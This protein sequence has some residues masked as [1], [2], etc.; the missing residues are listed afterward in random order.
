MPPSTRSVPTRR[1]GNQPSTHSRGVARLDL[2]SFDPTG[3]SL[4]DLA[5][6]P[7]AAD[8][9]R[10]SD[11]RTDALTDRAAIQ[12]AAFRRTIDEAALAEHSLARRADDLSARLDQGARFITELDSRLNAT[13]PAAALLDRA[14]SALVALESV[15]TQLRDAH[16]GQTRCIESKLEHHRTLVESAVKSHD[17]SLRSRLAEIERNALA[18]GATIERQ[19]AALTARASI[20]ADNAHEQFNELEAAATRVGAAARERLERAC[21][22]AAAILGHDPRSSSESAPTPGSLADLTAR[23]ESAAEATDEAILRLSAMTERA[24]ETEARIAR[25]L[26][27]AQRF[28]DEQSLT[29][30]RDDLESVAASVRYNLSQ[31]YQADAALLSRIEQSSS[32]LANLD[33]AMEQATQQATG[34]VHLARDAARLAQHAEQV[35]TDLA[36]TLDRAESLD[37]ADGLTLDRLPARGEDSQSPGVAA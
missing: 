20:L 30:L 10:S 34:L 18:A 23:A 7:A 21:E 31:A 15:L 26:E 19:S 22:S 27:Q 5:P 33:R 32:R 28:G 8:P 37:P 35:R 16:D 2:S 13:A 9:R 11:G 17:E 14:Q 24:D 36:S 3:E 29:T 6:S 12:L 25:L 4:A 1:S